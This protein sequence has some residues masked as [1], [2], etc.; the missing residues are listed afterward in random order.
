MTRRPVA[1]AGPAVTRTRT[2]DSEPPRHVPAGAGSA[3]AF[4][5]TMATAADPYKMPQP[6]PRW[7]LLRSEMT[8]THEPAGLRAESGSRP[9][10]ECGKLEGCGIYIIYIWSIFHET[11]AYGWIECILPLWVEE[12]EV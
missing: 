2:S 5:F 3:A 4:N 7:L 10:L 1:G 11:Q 9:S 6:R 8:D 12:S